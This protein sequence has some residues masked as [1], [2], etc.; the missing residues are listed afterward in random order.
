MEPESD[1]RDQPSK[2]SVLGHLGHDLDILVVWV[3][4]AAAV[5]AVLGFLGHLLHHCLRH[6]H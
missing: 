6:V 2:K 1:E 3:K 4:R 5:G